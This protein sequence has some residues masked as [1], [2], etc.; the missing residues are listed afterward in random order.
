MLVKQGVKE[1]VYFVVLQHLSD[2]A[3]TGLFES[4][5]PVVKTYTRR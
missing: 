5:C 3:K 2:M 1:S 4:Q